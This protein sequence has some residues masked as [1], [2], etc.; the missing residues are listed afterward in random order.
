MG[1][2]ASR[3]NFRDRPQSAAPW[4]G[5]QQGSLTVKPDPQAHLDIYHTNG[6]ATR[7]ENHE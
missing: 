6:Q 5:N 4:N 1:L 7:A 2:D 3:G